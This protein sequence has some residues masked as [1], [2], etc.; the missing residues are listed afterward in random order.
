MAPVLRDQVARKQ[1]ERLP[2]R[3]A[4]LHLHPEEGLDRYVR[5]TVVRAGGTVVAIDVGS[6][7]RDERTGGPL[8]GG[9][10]DRLDLLADDPGGHRVD[11]E[12]FHVAADAVRLQE[13][14]SA[15]HERI[16]D[17]QAREV[18][19][20]KEEILEGR[21]PELREQEAPKQGAR[22][23]GEPLVDADDR[24][25]VLLDLLLPERH[26]R[27]QGDIE[28]PLD[29]HFRFLSSGRF[30][31]A[32]STAESCTGGRPCPKS[33][34]ASRGRGGRGRRSG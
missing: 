14:G 24:A 7:R 16:G 29:A 18:I 34:R 17:P 6:Q 11:V 3:F 8:V 32:K 33:V 2:A 20:A 1:V 31:G 28:A 15:A 27:D 23:P 4:V 5:V 25:V 30:Q 21:L 19:R 10:V 22:T 13:R 26:F 9:D 12:A